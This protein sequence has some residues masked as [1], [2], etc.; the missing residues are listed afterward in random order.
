MPVLQII[1]RNAL[2]MVEKIVAFYIRI[3]NV[4]RKVGK[5][6]VFSNLFYQYIENEH[7]IREAYSNV[8]DCSILIYMYV[9]MCLSMCV[10]ACVCVC[11]CVC[12]CMCVCV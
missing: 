3:T 6:G 8:D 4:L 11:V 2:K 5:C 7:R 9:C 1:L 12:L 10:C